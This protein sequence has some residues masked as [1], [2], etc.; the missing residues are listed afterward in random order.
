MGQS[1]GHQEFCLY[2]DRRPTK[3]NGGLSNNLF[4]KNRQKWKISSNLDPLSLLLWPV[5]LQSSLGHIFAPLLQQHHEHHPCFWPTGQEC[6]QGLHPT[7]KE[8]KNHVHIKHWTAVRT[9]TTAALISKCP[10]CATGGTDNILKPQNI[11]KRSQMFLH[12]QV[13][14]VKFREVK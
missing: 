6:S 3:Q 14:I 10:L 5:L 12:C 8:R 13:R 4:S 7:M 2:K 1:R 11:S 9:R